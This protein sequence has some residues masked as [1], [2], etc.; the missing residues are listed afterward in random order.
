VAPNDEVKE[1]SVEGDSKNAILAKNE[2][3]KQSE[4][5]DS[6][7]N[8]EILLAPETLEKWKV[9]GDNL[10]QIGPALLPPVPQSQIQSPNEIP[11]EE[12]PLKVISSE[13]IL[14]KP[15]DVVVAPDMLAKRSLES[16]KGFVVDKSAPILNPLAKDVLNEQNQL[17][18]NQN[19]PVA[20][21][22]VEIKAQPNNGKVAE[23]RQKP[24]S[25]EEIF[26]ASA[27]ESNASGKLSKAIPESS[28]E[29]QMDLGNGDKPET[30]KDFA[31][32]L[33]VQNQLQSGG[34][35]SFASKLSRQLTVSDKPNVDLV[36]TNLFQDMKVHLEK[37]VASD[38]GG[39]V[40]ILMSPGD[41][42][43]VQIDVKV[44][45]DSVRIDMAAEKSSAEG[46]LKSQAG[47]LRNQLTAAGF[48]IEELQISSQ[49]SAQQE[50]QFSQ[51][52]RGF[53]QSQEQQKRQPKSDPESNLDDQ[54]VGVA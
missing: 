53:S 9:C 39:E 37:M 18:L 27:D 36:R 20:S 1:A 11:A 14:A 26:F 52:E 46:L 40:R 6:A 7:P 43:E 48:K 2:S 25:L 12:K 21:R 19:V 17:A 44:M 47:E 3:G 51:S 23:V 41:L 13:I 31:S 49:R 45:G 15:V 33:F 5:K 34:E 38:R 10:Q 50:K 22:P 35:T 42:G 28:P 30:L 8:T 4:G 16:E 29:S 24:K 32:S 54:M